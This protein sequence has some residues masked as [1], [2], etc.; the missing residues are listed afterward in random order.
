MIGVIGTI[1][2]GPLKVA[3][4][5][6]GVAAAEDGDEVLPAERLRHEFPSVAGFG[7]A[8]EGHA[9]QR[10]RIELGF[11]D[12]HQLFGGVLGAAQAR[13]FFFTSR[14]ESSISRRED[15]GR[16]HSERRD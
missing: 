3:G 16:E 14:T 4:A 5:G 10:R 6:F 15:S 8:S 1:Q 9:E 2:Q 12:F 13:F 7:V 11:H